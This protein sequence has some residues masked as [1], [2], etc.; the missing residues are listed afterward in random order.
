MHVMTEPSKFGDGDEALE[1]FKLKI[2]GLYNSKIYFNIINHKFQIDTYNS[3]SNNSSY[4]MDINV[5]NHYF[6]HTSHSCIIAINQNNVNNYGTMFGE[7]YLRQILYV[8]NDSSLN[9]SIL[10]RSIVSVLFDINI[11][12]LNIFITRHDTKTLSVGMKSDNLHLTSNWH[13][14]LIIYASKSSSYG[15]NF[16]F[17]KIFMNNMPKLISK[18]LK[19]Y[20]NMTHSNNSEP[21][22]AGAVNL[23]K[24]MNILNT[25]LD[26]S[27]LLIIAQ[28]VILIRNSYNINFNSTGNYFIGGNNNN[29]STGYFNNSDKNDITLLYPYYNDGEFVEDKLSYNSISS[30]KCLN[31]QNMIIQD[32]SGD[33]SHYVVSHESYILNNVSLLNLDDEISSIY[34][35]FDYF[36]NGSIHYNGG[37]FKV[38]IYIQYGNT[39]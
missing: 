1:I 30:L 2:Q 38:K 7:I 37:L 11:S 14:K 15:N 35:D 34:I 29:T 3:N 19:R 9:S 36:I 5:L 33:N 32:N 6:E 31:Y 10:I 12:N 17:S 18:S 27:Y 22:A 25:N 21:I 39:R 26:I 20:D 13:I 23:F 4:S 28:C 16:I 8:N 24:I